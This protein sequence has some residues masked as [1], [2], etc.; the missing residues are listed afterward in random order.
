MT[1]RSYRF[2]A[3][4]KEKNVLQKLT[5]NSSAGK[6]TFRSYCKST[7]CSKFSD[8]RA[9]SQTPRGGAYSTLQA[10]KYYHYYLGPLSIVSLFPHV[11][12]LRR[13]LRLVICSVVFRCLRYSH[14][15]RLYRTV[16]WAVSVVIVTSF[17]C[18]SGLL[19][20]FW[21]HV[22]SL[23]CSRSYCVLYLNY[24]FN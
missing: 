6:S 10:P 20:F 5:I 18:N 3:P 15:N 2:P 7:L 22:Y 9:Q 16:M 23:H 8:A 21:S 19:R 14:V 12:N 24:V 11:K 17:F 1:F 4:K 13:P